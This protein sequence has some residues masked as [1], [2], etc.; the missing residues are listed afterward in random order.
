MRQIVLSSKGDPVALLE[1][2][3]A[4]YAIKD[5]DRHIGWSANQRAERLKL[6][7]QN[8][9][10][11]LLIDKGIAPNL[12]SRA[13]A[14][15]L[16]ALCGQWEQ[17]HGY[18]PLMAET[19]TDPE[20]FEGTCYKASNWKAIGTS[21]GYSRHRA[22]L[23]IPNESP[24]NLWIYPLC[25]DAKKLL[26]SPKLPEALAPAQVAAP[27]GTLP[28]S[29]KHMLTLHELFG[30]VRDPRSKN[31]Q[32]KI[33]PMLT[34][35]AMAL[36]AGRRDITEITR[37]GQSLRP[38]QR[39]AIGLPLKPGTKYWKA[40]GYSVY[41][42]LL[43]RLDNEEFA[44]LLSAWLRERAGDLPDALA[45]DG[46]MIRDQIGTLTLASHE[47][48]APRAMAIHDK[49]EGTGRC[50]LKVAQALLGSMREL[51]G[52]IITADALHC[53][54]QTA[55]LIVERGG[56]YV[57]QI[58]GNQPGL[59]AH[60]QALDKQNPNAPLFSKSTRNTDAT[61]KENCA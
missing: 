21:A 51:E 20:R 39:Q 6:I 22:D 9:R 28:V 46:K 45:M 47:D 48:N 56:D 16:R 19:F 4:C 35:I 43:G 15:A 24:K 11:L 25:A 13:L 17:I 40:P 27:G 3:P 29:H 58:K 7:V 31:T 52:K 41:Y 32:F 1:W 54:K 50:E 8:R 60:S 42:Q 14:A 34:I 55:R 26:C 59:Q 49:K 33:R 37:F 12:A 38:N 36:L 23:Y 30:Q 57:L 18:A 2:G 10:F 61:R 5:R 44:A 53:Q